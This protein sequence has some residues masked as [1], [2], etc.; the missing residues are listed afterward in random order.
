MTD[1]NNSQQLDRADTRVRHDEGISGAIREF[2]RP[3]KVWGFRHASSSCW[4]RSYLGC[5]YFA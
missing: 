5:F 4:P 1:D 3:D 2:N